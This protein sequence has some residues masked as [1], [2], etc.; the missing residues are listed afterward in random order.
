MKHDQKLGAVSV[1]YSKTFPVLVAALLL[2]CRDANQQSAA[3]VPGNADSHVE[4]LSS[5][6]ADP[7]TLDLLAV[8]DL[9]KQLAARKGKVVVLDMWATW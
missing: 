7:V 5:R 9:P 3:P 8:Q 1:T 2:G 6:N 4:Q